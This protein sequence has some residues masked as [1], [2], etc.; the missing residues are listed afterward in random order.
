MTF[1]YRD[2]DGDTFIVANNKTDAG[3]PVVWMATSPDGVYIDLNRVEEV[4]AGIRDAA[5]TAARQTTGQD[6]RD[7]RHAL[8][9]VECPAVGQPNEATCTEDFRRPRCHPRHTDDCPYT[10]PSIAADPTPLRWGLGDVLHGDD[11]SVIVCLSGPAREPYWL[12][13]EFERAAAL[14][15]DLAA[16]AVGQPAEAHDTD[17]ALT[18]RGLLLDVLDHTSSAYLDEHFAPDEELGDVADYLI[19]LIR[20]E[21]PNEEQAAE[22]L[23]AADTVEDER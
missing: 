19:K 9:G 1:D 10:D 5:R 21:N 8:C 22:T 13:L 14:R 18:P 15:D 11:D 17:E 16:P 3:Q 6:E 23:A 20:E 4:V 12:E 2:A 7:P